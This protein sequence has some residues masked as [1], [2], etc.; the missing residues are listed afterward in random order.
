MPFGSLFDA[1]FTG[2]GGGLARSYALDPLT[3]EWVEISDRD[4]MLEPGADAREQNGA[5]ADD[6]PP[7]QPRTRRRRRS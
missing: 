6:G 3:G 2:G 7:P 4:S 5:R 1:L